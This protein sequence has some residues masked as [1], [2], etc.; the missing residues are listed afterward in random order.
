MTDSLETGGSPGPAGDGVQPPAPPDPTSDARSAA[1][2]FVPSLDDID[3]EVAEAM[4]AMAPADMAQLSGGRPAAVEPGSELVGTVV[5]VSDDDIFLELGQ[6]SQGLLPRS[7]FG[8]KESVEVGRRV[9]V[10]VERIDPESD[11]VIVNRKGAIQR[12]SWTNLAVGMIIEGKITGVIKGGLEVNLNGIRAFMPNSQVDIAPM[13]DVSI[14][15][16]ETVR[17]EVIEL[18]RRDKNVL[19]S[20]RK[21]IERDRAATREK[22]K[23]ELAVGQ[24]RKGIVKTIMEYGAFIDLGGIDGLAHIRELSWGNVEKVSDVLSPGQEV[25]VQL[26][27]IDHERDRIS[28]GI[29]QC[30]PDPWVGIDERCPVGTTLKVRVVRLANF[31]AFAE[32]EA[33]VEGLIPISEMGWSRV[34]KVSDVVSE[35]AMVDAVV[36]RLEADKRRIALSIKQAQPDPWEGV[37]ESYAVR[38]LITGRVTR[39]ADFGAFVE[40]SPGV[41]GLIHI[42]ELADRRVKTCADV[43]SVGQVVET[44]V[45]GVEPESRRI[46]LSIKQVNEPAETDTQSPASPEMPKKPKK[47]KK[48]LRGGLASHFDW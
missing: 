42:S 11:L 9:D 38:S 7:Q 13:K 36:L 2:Q 34:N 19:L 3:R 23:G 18:D 8:K 12:A 21:V 27:K 17:C 24:V 16:N 47:R 32:L 22:L 41:E 39:L 1:D 5:G 28:L 48:P 44:R 29:K 33:G 30:L 37:A 20:R 14:L 35:G 6:K 10:V 40:L 31:G 46:S 26:L 25:E 45:L 15:L 43:V 4:A